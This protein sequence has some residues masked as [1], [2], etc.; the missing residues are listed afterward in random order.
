MADKPANPASTNGKPT[1]RDNARAAQVSVKPDRYDNSDRLDPARNAR[2]FPPNLGRWAVPQVQTFAGLVSNIARAY[3]NP[4][5]AFKNSLDNARYMRND[6]LIM[7]CLEAR[8]R[9]V[10][11]LNWHLEVDGP[12]AKNHKALQE[13]LTGILKRTPR[14]TEYRRSILDAL[15]YGRQANQHK[16]GFVVRN[17]RKDIYIKKWLPIM[18]DKLVF[19]MDDG[20]NEHP[21]DQIGVR[22]GPMFREGDLIDGR[23]VVP[24]EAGMAVFLAP[25]ERNLIAVHKHMIE[26]GAY[27][28]P[29]SSGSI[30]GIGIRSRIYWTWFQKQELL[31]LFME[32]LERSALGFEI[33]YY[34]DGNPSGRADTE[35]AAKNRIGRRNIVLFPVKPGEERSYFVEHIEPGAAGAEAL[36]RVLSEYFGHQIKRYILGQTLSSEAAATG[37]GSGVAELH[38]QT[39]LD[40]VKYDAT[41]LE[42]TITTD[43]LDQLKILNDRDAANVDIRFVIETE[44]K[45]ADQQL[46]AYERAWNMGA[47]IPEKDVMEA[48]SSRMPEPGEPVLSN[49]GGTRQEGQSAA[50][51]PPKSD[52]TAGM[53]EAIKAEL[54][55][56]LVEEKP[57]AGGDEESETEGE[58][59]GPIQ[60]ARNPEGAERFAAFDESQH[61][62]D[63]GGQF[64]SGGGGSGKK[65][66]TNK[67]TIQEAGEG[68]A[69]KGYKLLGAAGFHP[70]NDSTRYNVKTPSGKTK[71]LTSGEIR[72]I[73]DGKTPSEAKPVDKRAVKR[74]TIQQAATLMEEKGYKITGGAD[75]DMAAGKARYKVT[76]PEGGTMILTSDEINDIIDRHARQGEPERYRATFDES[77]HP[78]GQPDNAGQF[79]PKGSSKQPARATR[80]V[81]AKREGKGKDAALTLSDGSKAPAHIKPSMVPPQWTDVQIST[82]PD[83]DVLVRARDAKGRLKTVYSDSFNM[84]NAAAKFARVT[85]LIDKFDDVY[86]ENQSNR[87]QSATKDAADCLWLIQEQATRPGSDRDTKA[88]VQA[89]GATTL[90]GEHVKQDPDGTVRLDFVG[91]E[92]V[93]HNHVIRNPDLAQM[94]VDRRKKAGGEGRLFDV[95]DNELRD[96]TRTL[97]GGSF[98]PKDFRT[99]KATRLAISEM[100]KIG[101]C[102]QN[103]KQFK[104][105]VKK[106][107][108]VV[109]GVL[110]NRPAQAVE[111]YIDPTV[112][113]A[114]RCPK[115]G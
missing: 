51:A 11:G 111:S 68:L 112:W 30:H 23:M 14:F 83:A 57:E 32:Y 43:V 28:D 60:F 10:A 79:A 77:E 58:A 69:G 76:D 72:D 44:N 5:E 33:W 107:A 82:D 78:R 89:F 95:T 34:D 97:D 99:A 1:A 27:E 63:D 47:K 48:I 7:E 40:I 8:Q 56:D 37:L 15:W 49:G 38:L 113:A 100:Q 4:D 9:A 54:G 87:S 25:Y 92:G 39:L 70:E 114:W 94:L 52:A 45:N 108:V 16:F 106:V 53:A 88:K 29:L 115:N 17:G 86:G 26:D 19:R 104:E 84:R 65:A 21:E 91:K 46:A 105:S 74:R 3:R 36:Q 35:A 66:T 96:Y 80:M 98:T 81:T 18:G 41:N 59:S 42:E 62:R 85:E 13:R 64:T 101:Q 6:L 102:C 55:G 12:D 90:R 50:G 20:R 24:T 109:S 67:I 22:V 93:H 103:E 110:G 2:D 75:F 73:I 31:G 61:P 71:Q